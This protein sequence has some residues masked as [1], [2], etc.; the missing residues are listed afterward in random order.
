M[1][2]CAFVGGYTAG[3]IKVSHQIDDC[4]DMQGITCAYTVRVTHIDDRGRCTL[5]IDGD[6]GVIETM[7]ARI[8]NRWQNNGKMKRVFQIITA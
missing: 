3:Y 5:V 7:T 8:V 4:F 6:D 2:V 1:Y